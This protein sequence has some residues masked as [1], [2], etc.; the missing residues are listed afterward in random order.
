ADAGRNYAVD[1]PGDLL[2]G[3]I[4][5]GELRARQRELDIERQAVVRPVVQRHF[6]A[7]AAA[8]PARLGIAGIADEEQLRVELEVP[9]R[10]GDVQPLREEAA[11]AELDLVRIDQRAHA[12]RGVAARRVDRD[13]RAPRVV[14]MKA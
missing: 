12:L 2:T 10:R 11:E 8:R 14:A 3:R 6:E 5:L 9:E 13:R 1:G 4:E 7:V